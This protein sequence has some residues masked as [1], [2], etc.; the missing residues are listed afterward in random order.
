V[1]AGPPALSEDLRPDK[2]FEKI[3]DK[4]G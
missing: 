3:V 1:P 2:V 4:N